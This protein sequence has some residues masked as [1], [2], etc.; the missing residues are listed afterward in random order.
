MKIQ[1]FLSSSTSEF[2]KERESL[3]AFTQALNNIY[4][5]RD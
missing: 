3:M 4:H 5:V 1:I 2:S